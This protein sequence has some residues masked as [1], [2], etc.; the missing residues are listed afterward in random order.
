MIYG[1]AARRSLRRRA[2]PK[3]EAPEH[4]PHMACDRLSAGRRVAHIVVRLVE[5]SAADAR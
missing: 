2:V 4:T 1:W 3:R 5:D